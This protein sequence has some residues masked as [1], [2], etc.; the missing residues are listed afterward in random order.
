MG[1]TVLAHQGGWDEILWV[2]LPVVLFVGLL[3]IPAW[4]V[5]L[6]VAR[7]LAITGLRLLAATKNVVLAAGVLGT[8]GKIW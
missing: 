7:E 4:M 1:M 2:A 6:V 8:V 3:W 5:V